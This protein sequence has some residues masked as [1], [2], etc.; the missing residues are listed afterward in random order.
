VYLHNRPVH[1]VT[2]HTL[3]EGFYGFKPDVGHLKLFGSRVCV[4]RSGNQ[5]AK[6]DWNNYTGLFLGYTAM[7][8][9]IL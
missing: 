7:D 3:I 5:P 8:N 6:L 4:K 2:K 1:T 9:N